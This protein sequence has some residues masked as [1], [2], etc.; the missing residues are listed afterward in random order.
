M[1]RRRTLPPWNQL[2]LLGRVGFDLRDK[3]RRVDW[4]G[5]DHALHGCSMGAVACLTLD[6]RKITD[7]GSHSSW[8]AN[9]R[10]ARG[11]RREPASATCP[12]SDKSDAP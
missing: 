1:R 3:S 8:L 2:A 10:S 5:G 12:G 4:D 7:S 6:W 11:A 9:P